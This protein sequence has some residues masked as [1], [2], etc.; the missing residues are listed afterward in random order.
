MSIQTQFQTNPDHQHRQERIGAAHRGRKGDDRIRQLQPEEAHQQQDQVGIEQR[1]KEHELEE[2]AQGRF[3]RF[4]RN[5]TGPTIADSGRS[6]GIADIEKGCEN[7]RLR[8]HQSGDIWH[9]KGPDIVA[10]EVDDSESLRYAAFPLIHQI[11]GD[12]Q[13]Q[14][15]DEANRGQKQ[16]VV[17]DV[18]RVETSDQRARQRDPQNDFRKFRKILGVYPSD[19]FDDVADHDDQNQ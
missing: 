12:L 15:S 19:P 6:E 7:D 11:A 10:A 4:I 17:G 16:Q 5:R 1:R 3:L 9:R 2:A 14:V 8:A 13:D 18:E